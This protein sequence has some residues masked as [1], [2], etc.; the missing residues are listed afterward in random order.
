M[1]KTLF[2]ALVFLGCLTSA[3]AAEFIIGSEASGISSPHIPTTADYRYSWSRMIYTKDEINASGLNYACNIE[4]LGVLIVNAPM[5]YPMLNQR[6]YM[7]HTSS[8]TLTSSYPGTSGFTLVYDGSAAFYPIWN[9]I[10][11][12]A[13][14]YWNNVSNL[15][16][17]WE[18]RANEISTGYLYFRLDTTSPVYRTAWNYSN[19]SFPTTSGT[20]EYTRPVIMIEANVPPNPAIS[21]YPLTGATYIPRN[22]KLTWQDGG[23][24]PTGYKL[25]FGIDNPPPFHSDLGNTLHWNSIGLYQDETYY[26]K[27]V[28]YND[29]GD[30]AGCPVWSFSTLPNSTVQIGSQTWPGEYGDWLPISPYH[31][32]SYTQVIYLQSEINTPGLYINNL[33]YYWDGEGECTNS[34][35]WTIYMGH[36]SQSDFPSLG[37]WVPYSQLTQ[38]FSGSIS[39]PATPGWINIPLDVWFAY[40]NMDN[41][42]IGVDQNQPGIDSH[43]YGL[44]CVTE[45]P[46]YRSRAIYNSSY[47]PDPADLPPGGSKTA[48]ANVLL[49]FT[50]VID[51]F[52]WIID[53]EYDYGAPMF[54]TT[55]NLD[56]HLPRWEKSWD[57]ARSGYGSMMHE[58]SDLYPDED[59]WLV[60][61]P[62]QIPAGT[63]PHKLRFWSYNEWPAYHVYN[64]V[65]VSTGSANPVDG[66]FVEIWS[67][68]T[69]S[70]SWTTTEISLATYAGQTIYIAFRYQGYDGDTWYLDDVE[71][72]EQ[73][74]YDVGVIGLAMP[75]VLPAEEIYPK[76]Y[77]ANYGTSAQSFN[78]SATIG[79]SYFNTQTVTSLAPGSTEIVY[80]A[81][82]V[83]EANTAY[84][85]TITTLLGIDQNP[86]NNVLEETLVS[87]NL[88]IQAF[89]D[90]LFDNIDDYEGLSS[91]SL[92]APHLLLNLPEEP[93][94]TNFIAGADWISGDWY[95]AEYD[96]GLLTT[97]RF[98]HIDS[99]EGIMTNMGSIGASLNGIAYD[100]NHQI[101]YG[102]SSGSLYR[103][104]PQT[105]AVLHQIGSYDDSNIVMVSIAYDSFSDVLYGLDL[106]YDALFTIDPVTGAATLVGPTG[107]NL[108]F[109]QDL[110]FDQTNGHLYLAGYASEL[111]A[112]FKGALY[113]IYTETGAAYKVGDFRNNAQVAGFAIPYIYTGSL[114]VPQVNISD[115]GVLSWNP[116]LTATSYNIYA[117]SDP[118]TGF[119]L[120]ANTGNTIWQDDSFPLEKRFYRVTAYN[121]GSRTLPQLRFEGIS[122]LEPKTLSHSPGN[123]ETGSATKANSTLTESGAR[124]P[125]IPGRS[126]H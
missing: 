65:W 83:L 64:G 48:I 63:F 23:G 36:T 27:I 88:D 19:T 13:P 66:D 84:G 53:F 94:Y 73:F 46:N 90:V 45:T 55:Y 16:I 30:A 86:A 126:R 60:T 67:A 25:Y 26:W 110:A 114:E 15:E 113:W 85:I 124:P 35:D 6:I 82:I 52:P 58:W 29:Y 7:R 79:T 99:E 9:M 105:G 121:P 44:F 18:N 37:D 56:G 119:S 122:Q 75:N 14:F 117:S 59:G 123:V 38:V 103:L 2:L 102:T 47:N 42:V 125:R 98:W 111:F 76:V 4:A 61:S 62:I 28:P 104:D 57:Q 72:F 107:L 50:E 51:S 8:S 1:K 70:E 54:W 49:G 87:L 17:L 108:G 118:Q 10:T 80:F 97:D 116:V 115:D 43:P 109:A 20:T 34:N 71:I 89:A 96:T 24:Y 74:N 91:F 33:A 3:I 69:V 95:G 32:Y 100:P 39:I 120:I 41:L 21:P 106:Y 78:V 68:S 93:I 5:G 112:P 12:S 11:L 22:V 31:Q 77:I 92:A 40:N 101:L 81:P